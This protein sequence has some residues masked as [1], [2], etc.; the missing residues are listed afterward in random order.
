MISKQR[1]SERTDPFVIVGKGLAQEREGLISQGGVLDHEQSYS[2]VWIVEGLAQIPE[3]VCPAPVGQGLDGI[4]FH[5][6]IFISE[7]LTKSRQHR[8]AI[9][10]V[11]LVEELEGLQPPLRSITL[12]RIEEERSC[13][14]LILLGQQG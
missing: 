14:L 9:R 6:A 8:L 2:G 12:C 5:G 10:L 1:R 3:R 4:T 13:S 7:R 11:N